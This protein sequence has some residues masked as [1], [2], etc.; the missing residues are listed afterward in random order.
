MLSQRMITI[1]LGKP[2]QYREKYFL[3]LP[4]VTYSTQPIIP[5]PRLTG[6]FFTFRP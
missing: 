2:W 1:E 4:I 5:V 6:F 3:A